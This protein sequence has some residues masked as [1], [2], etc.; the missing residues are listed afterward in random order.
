MN[1]QDRK[2][3]KECEER[4]RNSEA[5]RKTHYGNNGG[6]RRQYHWEII[7]GQKALVED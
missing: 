6:P 3:E 5:Y 1:E 4:N 7:A 2:L